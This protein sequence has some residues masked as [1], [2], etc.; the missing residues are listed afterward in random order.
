MKNY[1]AIYDSKTIK[2]VNYSFKRKNKEE[3]KTFCVEYFTD[4]AK[5]HAILETPEIFYRGELLS[6]REQVKKQKMLDVDGGSEIEVKIYGE[7]YTLR[8]HWSWGSMVAV[9]KDGSNFGTFDVFEY[10]TNTGISSI[11]HLTLDND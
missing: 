10:E 7:K 2:G 8:F 11:Y 4:S 9:K 5:H 1:T 6:L 3:A